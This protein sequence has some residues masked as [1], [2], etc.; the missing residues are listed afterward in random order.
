MIDARRTRLH[1][2]PSKPADPNHMSRS[3]HSSWHSLLRRGS[4]RGTMHRKHGREPSGSPRSIVALD[5]GDSKS[6]ASR[7]ETGPL[8][9]GKS[10]SW[11]QASSSP[12]LGTPGIECT[13]RAKCAIPHRHPSLLA[14][15]TTRDRDFS[16]SFPHAIDRACPPAWR[17]SSAGRNRTPLHM[18]HSSA[19]SLPLPQQHDGHVPK[20]A[21]TTMSTPRCK[22]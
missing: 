21:R 6:R 17:R 3:K 22:S 8:G 15:R 7:S 14:P 10:M 2:P 1:P 18:A 20:G 13:P 11:R 19:P 9:R 16:G 4:V 5:P 12:H